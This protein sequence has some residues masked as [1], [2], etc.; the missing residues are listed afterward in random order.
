MLNYQKIIERFVE[1]EIN[2]VIVGGFAA[3]SHGSHILTQD[4]DLCIETDTDVW[5]KVYSALKDL[6]PWHRMTPNRI[7]FTYSLSD[8]PYKN[9]Y[10][11]TDLG[12][13]DLL[14]RITGVGEFSNVLKVSDQVMLG[15]NPINILGIDA[16]I[17]SK[18]SLK[19]PKDNSSIKVLKSLRDNK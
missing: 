10:L 3:I 6:H 4:L 19:R 18:E 5:Y 8:S 12:Q 9:L 1:N 13:L 14:G 16:L 17:S 2:F 11:S 15:T 7:P